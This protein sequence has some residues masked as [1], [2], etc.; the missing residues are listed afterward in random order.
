MSKIEDKI[1]GKEALI[2]KKYLQKDV[3]S[4]DVIWC[5]SRQGCGSNII[6]GR[7]A[8]EMLSFNGKKKAAEGRKKI[9]DNGFLFERKN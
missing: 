6:N 7:M 3:F 2:Q 9:S 5:V 1:L 4:V 8:H